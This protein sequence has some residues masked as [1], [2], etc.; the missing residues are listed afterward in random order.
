MTLT[1][2]VRWCWGYEGTSP[3]QIVNRTAL[4]NTNEDDAEQ[5]PLDILAEQQPAKLYLLIGTNAL[6][7][8]G[9]DEAFWRITANCWMNCKAR[10]PTA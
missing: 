1:W 6:A 5:V 4:K 2:V 8:L 9:N 10:C 3:N 7:G